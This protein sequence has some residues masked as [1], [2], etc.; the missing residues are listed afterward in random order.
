M[1]VLYEI[2]AS[3]AWKFMQVWSSIKI[4]YGKQVDG[5]SHSVLPQSH[6]YSTDS[7]LTVSFDT[8]RALSGQGFTAIYSV[9]M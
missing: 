3:F 7:T 5:V 6:I 9:G 4:F 8:N 2:H 1:Q